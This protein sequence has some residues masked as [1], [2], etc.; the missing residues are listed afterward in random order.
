MDTVLST[1]RQATKER[2]AMK[3]RI[4]VTRPLPVP[5]AEW[6]ARTC[7]VQSHPD[8]SSLPPAELGEL[9]RDMDGL[10]VIFAR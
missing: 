7:D 8:D 5:V 4:F 6:L 3:P 1:P 10:L 2:S 9:C